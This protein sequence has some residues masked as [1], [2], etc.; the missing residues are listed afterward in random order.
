[1]KKIISGLLVGLVTASFTMTTMAAPVQDHKHPPAKHH[2]D[3][4]PQPSKHD[5]RKG[6]DHK[7]PSKH[8]AKKAPFHKAPIQHHVKH[9]GHKNVKHDGYQNHKTPNRHG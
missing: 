3:Q 6:A 1:M 5:F 7:A 9:D 4:K 8:H 2:I